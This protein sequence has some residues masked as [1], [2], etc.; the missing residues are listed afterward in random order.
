VILDGGRVKIAASSFERMCA[1]NHYTAIIRLPKVLAISGCSRSYVYQLISEGLW[2]KS[3]RL[4][5][6]AVGWPESEVMA[7]CAARIAGKSEAEIRR[8]IEQLHDLRSATP[9]Y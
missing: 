7:V 4:G 2:P 5:V 8:L 9:T 3:I 1:M 6:R